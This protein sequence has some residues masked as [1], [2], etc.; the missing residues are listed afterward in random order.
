MYINIENLLELKNNNYWKFVCIE[1]KMHSK[2]VYIEKLLE[3]KK[4]LY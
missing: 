4:I 3:L 1:K 2:I